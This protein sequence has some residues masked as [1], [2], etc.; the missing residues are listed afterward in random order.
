MTLFC[1]LGAAWITFNSAVGEDGESEAVSV[2]DLPERARVGEGPPVHEE[3]GLLPPR[4]PRP[5]PVL[6]LARLLDAE[7]PPV[8][9]VLLAARRNRLDFIK[10]LK[11][12]LKP[13]VS[14]FSGRK[15]LY[16]SSQPSIES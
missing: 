12:E 3:D 8:L 16:F 10:S 6:H 2:E 14:L 1:A 11:T 5:P 15:N 4:P 13:V 7:V 9:R